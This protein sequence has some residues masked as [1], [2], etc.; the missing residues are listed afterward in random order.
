[1]FLHALRLV[2]HTRLENLDVMTEDPFTAR[3]PCN[4]WTV[5]ETVTGLEEAF[6]LIHA[7]DGENWLR[8]GLDCSSSGGP[9]S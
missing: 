5:S 4:Q 7:E 1:M 9:A 2:L 6:E 3:D 8:V